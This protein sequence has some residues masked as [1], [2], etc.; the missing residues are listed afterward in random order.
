MK[1][2]VER[3]GLAGLLAPYV[4]GMAILIVLPA[5]ITFILSLYQYDLI[6]PAEFAGTG[7]FSGLMRDGVFQISLRNSLF[8][9]LFAVPLRLLGAVVLALLLH[10]RF[11]GAGVYR[12]SAYLPTVVPDVAYALLWLWILNPLYGP[13]N[14]FLGLF[15][16]FTPAWQTNPTAAQA[17]IIL[18][19][20]FQIGEG[21][22]VAMATRQSIPG[23][24][25]ELAAI[26]GSAPWNSFRR[27][28]LPLMA[29]TLLLLLFRDTIFSFQ[30][31][32]VPALIVTGG[33]PPPYATTYLPLFIYRNAF[34]YLR[35]GYA[36]AATLTMF[37]ITAVIV[38][39][40]WRIVKRWRHALVV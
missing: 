20:L 16:D 35:Y 31:N 18:M 12:T 2:S 10:K 14:L 1:W 8:Y 22:V 26:E 36:A 38:F 24:L 30:A 17:G 7:N 27:I 11:R 33:G 19:S 4:A 21:F 15:G 5:A 6:R 37:A 32:F 39:I 3:R 40:Q 29:P 28:T 34:E 25:Y 9:I 13:L 23:E